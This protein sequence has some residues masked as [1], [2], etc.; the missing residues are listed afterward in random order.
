MAIVDTILHWLVR[1][2]L[3][4]GL[5]IL[6]YFLRQSSVQQLFNAS[7]LA[8]TLIL[9]GALILPA[10]ALGTWSNTTAGRQSIVFYVLAVLSIGLITVLGMLIFALEQAFS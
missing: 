7:N 9:G 10:I 8:N 3:A 2:S 1:L 4:A 5:L 6:V